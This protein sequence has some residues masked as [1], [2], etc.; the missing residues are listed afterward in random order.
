MLREKITALVPRRLLVR[1]LGADHRNCV[2]LT[3]DDGPDPDI[4]PQVLQRLADFGVRALFF[5]VGRR[6]VAAPQL[7]REIVQAGHILGNHTYEHAIESPPSLLAYRDDLRRCQDLLSELGG[8]PP[9]YFRP[10][11]GHLSFTSLLAPLPLGLQTV[12]WRS[13]GGDW[14]CRNSEDAA[15]VGARLKHEIRPGHVVLLHDLTAHN[16]TILDLLLPWLREAGFDLHAGVDRLR[17]SI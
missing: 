2:L 5:L 14:N 10:P 9:H 13:G 8:K 11:G 12:T 3:F 15:R 1:D 17:E 6:V 4:T 7:V 16:L